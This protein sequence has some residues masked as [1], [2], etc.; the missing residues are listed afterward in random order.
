MIFGNRSSL[1]HQKLLHTAKA[2]GAPGLRP[3]VHPPPAQQ[4]TVVDLTRENPRL[5]YRATPRGIDPTAS[6]EGTNRFFG[7]EPIVSLFCRC[8]GEV[9][10]LRERVAALQDELGKTQRELRAAQGEFVALHEQV[11]KRWRRALAVERNQERAGTEAPTA[12]PA[13]LPVTRND[14]IAA[15]LARR[16]ALGSGAHFNGGVFDRPGGSSSRED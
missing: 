14:R 1:Q 7:G 13:P 16:R 4:C 15:A 6:W 11:T 10:E 8:K 5:Q 2:V 9:R 12:T 3:G